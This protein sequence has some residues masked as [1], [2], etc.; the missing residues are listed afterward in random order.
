[1]EANCLRA[2]SAEKGHRKTTL[3]K[4]PIHCAAGH[5]WRVLEVIY[6][7]KYESQWREQTLGSQAHFTAYLAF[8]HC[9]METVLQYQVR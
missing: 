4:C 6:T 9:K 7:L 5:F 3:S 2:V 8:R 1:M